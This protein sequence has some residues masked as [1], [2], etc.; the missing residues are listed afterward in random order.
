MK[1]TIEQITIYRK[2]LHLLAT[3][4]EIKEMIDFLLTD[5]EYSQ[6]LKDY[7]D[8]IDTNSILGWDTNGDWDSD[9]QGGSRFYPRNLV[10]TFPNGKVDFGEMIDCWEIE[11]YNN[12]DANSQDFNP[13]AFN[14]EV[15]V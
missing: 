3:R 4:Q 11:F 14:L 7:T 10:V 6:E 1:P 15:V 12:W 13:P 9:D 2:H 8:I 5:E